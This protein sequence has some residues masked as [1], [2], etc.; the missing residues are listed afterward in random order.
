[1]TDRE[2][3]E[4]QVMKAHCAGSAVEGGALLLVHRAAAYWM[5]HLLCYMNFLVSLNTMRNLTLY[6]L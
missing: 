1:M 2:T 5:P 6:C 4:K 3:T